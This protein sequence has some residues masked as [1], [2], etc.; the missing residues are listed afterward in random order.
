MYPLSKYLSKIFYSVS[1]S[2]N[3]NIV[4]LRLM[5]MGEINPMKKTTPLLGYLIKNILLNK[6]FKLYAKNFK[7]DYIYR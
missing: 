3:L 2:Y 6:S 1:K 7:R 5:F 4:N